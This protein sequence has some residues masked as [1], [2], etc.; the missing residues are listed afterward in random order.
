[1]PSAKSRTH[2]RV[3]LPPSYKI[4]LRCLG[5]CYI[6]WPTLRTLVEP[7]FHQ[8]PP[9]ADGRMPLHAAPVPVMAFL[10]EVYISG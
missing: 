5:E 1:M 9:A 2:E 3:V 10:C 6:L 8:E 7:I 4:A